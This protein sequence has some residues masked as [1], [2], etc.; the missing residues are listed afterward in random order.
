M[1]RNSW[2]ST[3][4]RFGKDNNEVR[5][6]G[7]IDFKS[8]FIFQLQ[9]KSRPTERRVA[10]LRRDFSP[11]SSLLFSTSSSPPTSSMNTHQLSSKNPALLSSCHHLAS[12]AS[13]FPNSTTGSTQVSNPTNLLIGHGIHQSKATNP[14]GEM[15]GKNLGSVN[16]GGQDPY[17]EKVRESKTGEEVTAELSN[18][19]STATKTR[20][21]S[22]D[23]KG[24]NITK[25]EKPKDGEIS[26]EMLVSQGEEEAGWLS[27]VNPGVR[28][29]L[30]EQ[31]TVVL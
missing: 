14:E 15:L 27:K 17:L 30:K 9:Q 26:G 22:E 25:D 19:K 2:W 8:E 13:S 10:Q 6:N 28:L 16:T 31:L 23:T 29:R 24:T 1:T 12:V 4:C 11:A 21:P 5:P 20:P 7:S 18:G 3:S